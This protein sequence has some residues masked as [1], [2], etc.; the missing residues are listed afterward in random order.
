MN[1]TESYQ[2]EQHRQI[3]EHIKVREIPDQSSISL[4]KSLPTLERQHSPFFLIHLS[5]SYSSSSTSFSSSP[6]LPYSHLHLLH[7]Y[8]I[9]LL[10]P[11]IHLSS[12]SL[13]FPI[14]SP[15]LPLIHLYSFSLSFPS[16]PLIHLYSFSL[17][18]LSPPHLFPTSSSHLP[19][20]LPLIHLSSSLSFT[21]PSSRFLPHLFLPHFPHLTTT[22]TTTTTSSGLT[23]REAWPQ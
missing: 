13:S 20:L 8:P 10:L 3:Q 23:V 19:L 1:I 18:F 2:D 16:H 9:P 15:L 14:S 5:T 6:P 4:G 17:S 11:L 22:T 21:S 7:F 12:F